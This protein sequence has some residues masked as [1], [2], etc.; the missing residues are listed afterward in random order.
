MY[1][2]S[3]D[4]PAKKLKKDL[5]EEPIV[6]KI[7]LVEKDLLKRRG[8]EYKDYTEQEK[9]KLKELLGLFEKLVKTPYGALNYI[10]QTEAENIKTLYDVNTGIDFTT[11]IDEVKVHVPNPKLDSMV[12]A[13][14]GRRWM[15]LGEAGEEVDSPKEDAKNA[16]V[17]DEAIEEII[18]SIKDILSDG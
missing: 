17:T 12:E 15:I 11:D 8:E 10:I 3:Y 4:G 18:D 9:I 6:R 13:G 5:E 16:K 14:G 2:A 7:H 1:P